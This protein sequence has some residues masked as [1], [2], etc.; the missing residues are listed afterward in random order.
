MNWLCD[1]Y[2]VG[3]NGPGD[4]LHAFPEEIVELA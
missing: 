1:N 2:I 3:A 4:R